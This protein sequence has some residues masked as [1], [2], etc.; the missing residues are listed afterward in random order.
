MPGDAQTTYSVELTAQSDDLKLEV[1]GFGPVK[2]P[3]APAKSRERIGLGQPP[4]CDRSKQT[5]TDPDVRD[6]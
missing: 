5:R 1:E 4:R 6:T 3:V 2:F